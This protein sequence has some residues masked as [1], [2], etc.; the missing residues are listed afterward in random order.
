MQVRMMHEILAPGM[1]NGYHSGHAIEILS[2]FRE[3]DQR[4]RSRFEKDI[5]H[6]GRIY[7]CEGVD[8]RR[9]RENDMKIPDR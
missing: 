4:F 8:F 6:D 9:N 1:Q 2:V 3:C 7:Q 5:L